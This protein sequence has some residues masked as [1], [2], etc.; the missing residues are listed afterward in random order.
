MTKHIVA[1]AKNYESDTIPGDFATLEA[2]CPKCGGEVHERYKKFQCVDCDFGFWKIMGGRQLAPDEAE[3]LL[4]ERSVGPLDGFR[5]RL[6]RPFSASLKLNAGNE[7]EFDFGPKLDDDEQEAPDFSGQ[8]P[9]GACPK[10]GHGVYETANAYVCERAVGENR[11]CDFRSGRTILQRIVDRAQMAK[12]L[13]TGKTDLLQFVSARTRRPFSA[14][15]VKQPDGKVGFEFE[16]K[17]P[18]RRGARP[19]QSAPLRV[20]G[21]HPR[22]GQPVE[23]HAGRYGPYVKHGTTNATLPDRDAVD[24]LTLEQAIALVDEK[25]ERSGGVTRAVAKTRA[26][27]KVREAAPQSS[28]PP[29]A[30]RRVTPDRTTRPSAH[31]A[32]AATKRATKTPAAKRT[33]AATKK[34]G[35][36]RASGYGKTGVGNGKGTATPRAASKTSLAALAARK[37]TAK[38]PGKTKRR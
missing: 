20:L 8:T 28:A 3:T 34:S 26:P 1:Q 27:R 11:Q 13:E 19:A 38:A 33:P 31:A 12:L 16:A 21:A 5:S 2:R 37:T 7:V 36:K 25:A 9:V 29:P 24:T 6:G 18:G 35:T 14:Y 17:A 10:C 30:T 23:L 22:D 32:K 4:T 15:L